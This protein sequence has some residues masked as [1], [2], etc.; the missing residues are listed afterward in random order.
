MIR[1]NGNGPESKVGKLIDVKEDFFVLY[2]EEDGLIFYK[3][4]HIKSLS[5]GLTFTNQVIAK[6]GEGLVETSSNE[7]VIQEEVTDPLTSIMEVYNQIS[8]NNTNNLLTNLKLSWIKLNRKGPESIEGLLVEANENY[9]V[10][11][12]NNEIF[13]IPTY[14]VQNFSV[15]INKS[16]KHTCTNSF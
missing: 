4:Q 6:D 9:L 2:T 11:I 10:L 14:H 3:E 8:A 12:V 1:I 16:Y 13:R 15:N 7:E 5:H